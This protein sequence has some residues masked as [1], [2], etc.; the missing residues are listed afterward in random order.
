MEITTWHE[1]SGKPVTVL[2]VKG[3]LTANEPLEGQARQAFANGT[4]DIVL[5][6]SQVNYISSAGLR[7]I[8]AIYMLLRSADA[9]DEENA[10]RGIARGVYKSPHLKLVKPSKNG[11]KALSTAGYDMFLDIHDSI[12]AAV[13]SFK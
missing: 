5:D 1:T 8:H 6:L 7:V 3:D 9:D 11:L 12:P 2:Q 13:A 4:R 10:A